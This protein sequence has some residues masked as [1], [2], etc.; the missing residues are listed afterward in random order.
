VIPITFGQWADWSGATAEGVNRQTVIQGV[1]IDSR[2]VRADEL[3]V[4]LPGHETHGHFFVESA[5]KRGAAALVES[6]YALGG[7]PLLRVASP[8]QAMADVVRHL[9]DQRQIQVVGVT[10]SVGKTSIKELI[11][12]VLSTQFVTGVTQGNF[13]TAIGIPLSFFS[14]DPRMTHFVAEMGMRFSGEI[15]RLTEITPPNLAVIS[16]VGPSH[17]ETL[18]S[19][20][21]IQ[22]A[23]GE[24]LQ[25]LRPGGTAV[26]NFDDP[27]VRYLG[28]ALKDRRVLWYGETQ[29]LDA[30]VESSQ[31][32]GDH[33][34]VR[35]KW[36]GK[37]WD[38]RL[39]WMGTHQGLNVGAA[40]LVGIGFGLAPDLVVRG[41]EAVAPDRSRIRRQTVGSVEVIEDDYNASPVSMQ[42]ALAFLAAQPGRRLAVLGDILEL[43][44]EEAKLHR[45][46]GV[47][48]A[49]SAD[50]LVTVGERARLIGEEARARELPTYT[51]GTIEEAYTLLTELIRPGDVILVKASHGMGLD[52]LVERLDQWGGPQ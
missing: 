7:G 23:K 39:P 42:A 49:N 28:A 13:N 14:T 48:A 15:R 31:L 44:H 22:A 8:L 30:T 12:A 18:G 2:L 26:L 46:V 27:R 16:N 43:G 33:T 45:Q 4:A 17:L 21:A 10:G 20:D 38:I 36:E 19:L 1:G 24:I 29:G 41:L 47:R 25:G 32:D 37:R 50:L 51:A 35:L 11:G 3:F 9:V 5:W 52:R 6:S 34:L 40:F